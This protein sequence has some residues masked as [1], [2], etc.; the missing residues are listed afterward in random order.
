MNDGDD[1]RYYRARNVGG[2]LQG[3]PSFLVQ[4]RFLPF[5]KSFM[6]YNLQFGEILFHQIEKCLIR[7]KVK[8]FSRKHEPL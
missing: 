4:S 5:Q 7:R 3:I 8:E 2:R 1:Q 6:T